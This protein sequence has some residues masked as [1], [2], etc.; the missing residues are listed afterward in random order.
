MQG[1]A[2]L[3]AEMVGV[4]V[5]VVVVAVAVAVA[6]AVVAAVVLMQEAEVTKWTLKEVD[7][8]KETAWLDSELLIRLENQGAPRNEEAKKVT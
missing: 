7:R 3:L 4:L 1:V 5:V 2:V 8:K 6:V